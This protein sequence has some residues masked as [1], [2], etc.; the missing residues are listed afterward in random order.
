MKA[1]T[2]IKKTAEL[3]CSESENLG[4][5]LLH[6][7]TIT[8]KK[9]SYH[10]E[11]HLVKSNWTTWMVILLSIFTNTIFGCFIPSPNVKA[12]N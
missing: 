9:K 1:I 3:W 12:V 2:S 7:K 5:N 11:I 8:L 10:E 6:Q 4:S